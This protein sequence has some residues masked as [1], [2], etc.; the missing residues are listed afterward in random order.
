M[1]VIV[2]NIKKIKNGSLY[3]DPEEKKVWR[4]RSRA[5]TSSLWMSHHSNAALLVKAGGLRETT[6]AERK[7][8]LGDK[9]R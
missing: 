9:A 2:M 7:E 8:Y 4:A 3:F 1:L 5:N 6:E